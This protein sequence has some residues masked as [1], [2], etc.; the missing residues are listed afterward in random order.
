MIRVRVELLSA[1]TGKVTE[2]ARMNIC[3][4]GGTST[5][6]DYGVYVVRGRGTPQ[7][8]TSEWRRVFTKQAKITGHPRLAEHV[9]NL[10]G[11]ALHAAGYKHD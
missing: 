10:V 5:K 1:I 3:N 4:E 11:K 8:D 2:L 9:W 7:L 6:G